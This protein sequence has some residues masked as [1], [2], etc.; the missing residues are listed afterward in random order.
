MSYSH[1]MAFHKSAEFGVWDI[2][3]HCSAMSYV[4]LLYEPA[5][6]PRLGKPKF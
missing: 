1:T 3:L 6:C 5:D 4:A 2:D